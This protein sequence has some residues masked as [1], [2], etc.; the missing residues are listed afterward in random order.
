MSAWIWV[1]VGRLKGRRNAE[2]EPPARAERRRQLDIRPLPAA[3]RIRFLEQWQ[4]LQA[5]FVDDPGTAVVSAASLIKYAMAERG[6][7][8][9][10][11]DQRVADV[12]V[13]HPEVAED[14]RAGHRLAQAGANGDGSTE[15]LRQ[16]MRRYR[17]LFDEL[18][19]PS[20][21]DI[22]GAVSAFERSAR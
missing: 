17:A 1:V 3:S 4:V 13:D 7:P 6:Y 2:A 10:D 15:D 12:S 8:V 16:A 14:Y 19:G 22:A 21:D 18:V 20:A 11:F 5:Q 9:E